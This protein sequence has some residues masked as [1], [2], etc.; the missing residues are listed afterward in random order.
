[1]QQASPQKKAVQRT[2]SVG[3][4]SVNQKLVKPSPTGGESIERVKNRNK[5]YQDFSG[6]SLSSS[7]IQGVLNVMLLSVV[8][9]LMVFRPEP[10]YFT[11]EDGRITPIIPVSQAVSSDTD[12]VNWAVKAVTE[13][14]SIDFINYIEQLTDAEVYF[15]PQGYGAYLQ[16]LKDSGNLD[17]ISQN[18]YVVRAVPTSGTRGGPRI[19]GRTV[20]GALMYQLEIPLVVSYHGAE[21][22]PTQQLKATVLATRVPQWQNKHGLAIQQLVLGTMQ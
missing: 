14:I 3:K 17:S 21:R 2:N 6:K 1:M 22:G 11:T 18:K 19:T 7:I 12:V 20:R 9:G 15:T 10:A 5:W 4:A 16:A 8:I 13:T